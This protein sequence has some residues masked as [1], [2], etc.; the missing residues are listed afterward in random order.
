MKS[1]DC[2]ILRWSPQAFARQPYV[3]S[4][5]EVLVLGV[6]VDATGADS[7]WIAAIVLFVFLGLCN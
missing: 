3:V 6:D 2:C 4:G 5:A 1:I 7:L